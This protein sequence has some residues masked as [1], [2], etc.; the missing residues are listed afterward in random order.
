[1][2]LR[3]ALASP[4]S[5]PAA[6]RTLPATRPLWSAA[7]LTPTMFDDTSCVPAEAC[8][9]LREISC[10]AAACSSMAA[11]IAAVIWSIS[12]MVPPIDSIAWT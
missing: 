10:V 1:M 6:S 8:W 7:S 11:A 4:D 12:R 9:T 3:S 2:R 5:V